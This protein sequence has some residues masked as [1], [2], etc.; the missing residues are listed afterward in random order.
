MNSMSFQKHSYF[1]PIKLTIEIQ[2]SQ[3]KVEK[4]THDYLEFCYIISGRILHNLN[5]KE[6]FLNANDFFCIDRNAYHGLYPLEN[7]RCHLINIIFRPSFIDKTL[8]DNATLK[9]VLASRNIEFREITTDNLPA[10]CTYH[11]ADKYLKALILDIKNEY[12]QTPFGYEYKLR[13]DL[14]SIL[15]HLVRCVKDKDIISQKDTEF[16]RILSY[17]EQHLDEK[18]TLKKIGKKFAYTDTYLCTKFQKECGCSFIEYMQKKRIAKSCELL[19]NTNMKI[20]EISS[21]IGYSDIKYFGKVFRKYMV[22]SPSEYRKF[23][24]QCVIE[25]KNTLNE[26]D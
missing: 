15:I 22:N 21:A 20:D 16:Y 5:G 4:H 2:P 7:E 18:L 17:I 23:E 14:I 6:E 24:K 1:L 8:S 19:K 13:A 3:P 26:S 9:E 25:L 10:N 11:D 12:D